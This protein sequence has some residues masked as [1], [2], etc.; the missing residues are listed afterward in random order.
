LVAFKT[1]NNLL[2][3]FGHKKPTFSPSGMGGGDPYPRCLFT[4]IH[5]MEFDLYPAQTIWIM[6]IRHHGTLG[7]TMWVRKMGGRRHFYG[8]RYGCKIIGIVSLPITVVGDSNNRV[9]PKSFICQVEHIFTMNIYR[10][11][12]LYPW[13]VADP[14]EAYHITALHGSTG[15]DKIIQLLFIGQ[16]M[17][18]PLLGLGI[19]KY[20]TLL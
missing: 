5:P 3:Y 11:T 17:V 9:L 13:M 16:K 18:V 20:F 15:V 12:H 1:Y 10:P 2:P 7:F 6:V 4:A 19:I 14:I 8:S